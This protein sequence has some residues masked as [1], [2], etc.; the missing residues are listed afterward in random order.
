LDAE[1]IV[2]VQ[3]DEP[4]TDPSLIDELIR[5]ASSSDADMVTPVIK[6]TSTEVLTS[7]NTV[8]V[9][10]REDSTALYFSRSPIP[11]VRDV[12][13]EGWVG[14]TNFWLQVGIYAFRR[15]ALLEYRKWP[16]SA[17]ERLEKIEQLRFLEA[18]KKILT[19]ETKSQ[20]IAVDTP[21]DLERVRQLL[22]E[23][24]NSVSD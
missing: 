17:L 2:N 11:F 10:V 7:H 18:G 9:V 13:L 12:E 16:E 20:S 3:G 8:K 19:F 14:K 23:K 15:E 24:R 5:R 4:L 6:I 21:D 1:I 22:A